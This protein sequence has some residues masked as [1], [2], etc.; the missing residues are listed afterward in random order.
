MASAVHRLEYFAAPRAVARHRQSAR[1]LIREAT[2]A[3]FF[4]SHALR[5]S[6]IASAST[7]GSVGRPSVCRDSRV[8][9]SAGVLKPRWLSVAVGAARAPAWAAWGSC[10]ALAQRP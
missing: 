3:A 6:Y 7:T 8:T 4:D 2:G 1:S 5:R 9:L 10:H